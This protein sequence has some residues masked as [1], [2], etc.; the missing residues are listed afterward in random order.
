MFSVFGRRLLKKERRARG[1]EEERK[2][3]GRKETF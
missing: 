1:R 2:E 3:E